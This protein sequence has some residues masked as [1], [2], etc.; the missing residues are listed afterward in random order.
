MGLNHSQQMLLKS[1][2]RGASP[3]SQGPHPVISSSELCYKSPRFFCYKTA[4]SFTW[5][6][7]NQR[8]KRRFWWFAGCNI[9]REIPAIPAVQ[10]PLQRQGQGSWIRLEGTDSLW[11]KG[12]MGW[13]GYLGDRFFS[14]NLEKNIWKDQT[15]CKEGLGTNY[16]CC[17]WWCDAGLLMAQFLWCM[18]TFP[19]LS[20][21]LIFLFQKG[22]GVFVKSSQNQYPFFCNL[23]KK[24]MQIGTLENTVCCWLLMMLFLVHPWKGTGV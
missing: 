18:S 4:N 2:M 7:Q 6:N 3:K 10:R 16:Q 19:V 9:F 24:A 23:L 8:R 12:N 13:I 17:I 15:F 14:W 20:P 21:H 22:D 5:K 11:G 1:N